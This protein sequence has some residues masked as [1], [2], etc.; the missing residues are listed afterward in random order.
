MP[1]P[2]RRAFRAALLA[3]A[4]LIGAGLAVPL[5]P[6][7]RAQT[8]TEAQA[9]DVAKQLQAWMSGIVGPKLPIPADILRVVPDGPRYR[10]NLPV[11][12]LTPFL[13]MQDVAGK[14]TQALLSV[15]IRPIE[16]TKWRVEALDLPSVLT[17]TPEGAGALAALHGTAGAT[18]SAPSSGAQAAP[19]AAQPS[20]EMRIRAQSASG[21]YDTSLATESRFEWRHEGIAYVARNIG[22]K[23]E[24][25]SA[26]DLSTGVTTLKPNGSGGLSVRTEASMEGYNALSNTAMG[27]LRMTMKRVR[28]AGELSALMTAQFTTIVQTVVTLGMEAQAAK[29]ADPKTVDAKAQEAAK[30]AGLR[31][32][33]AALK[34]IMGGMTLEET[35]E[36][37]DVDV[38]GQQGSAGK[39]TVSLGGG[40][41]ADKFK[42]FIEIGLDALKIPALPPQYLDLLPRSIAVRPSVGNI[43]VKAMTA[44]AEQA[45]ADDADTAALEAKLKDL[46][47]KGGTELGL[48]RLVIDLGFARLQANGSAT[49]VDE[50]KF[51]GAGE[52]SMTGFDA[53]MDRAQKMPEAGMAIPMLALLKGLGKTEGDRLIWRLTVAE[54][55]KVLVNGMDISKLGK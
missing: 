45:A 5:V 54:D 52:I 6:A 23:G 8:V 44:L 24:D 29:A 9:G 20:A 17:L 27:P 46:V 1:S 33:I 4:A 38:M 49:M 12:A 16:G 28:M 21:V 36:G 32:V 22:G 25:R 26:I 30:R 55:Q 14:P 48:D 39:L 31:K 51:K 2:S 43:D 53:L 3:S 47:T 35:I 7:A 18:P 10:I 40:A 41:P 34:G 50:D 19:A 11:P 15:A 42:A 13:T 37:I